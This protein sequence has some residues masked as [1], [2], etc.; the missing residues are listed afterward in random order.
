MVL[1]N[2]SSFEETGTLHWKF[3]VGGG[4][5]GEPGDLEVGFWMHSGG[6]GLRL[7]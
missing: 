7:R 4:I 1:G 6:R 5:E 3:Q 2:C